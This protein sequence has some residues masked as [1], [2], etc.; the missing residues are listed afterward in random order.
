MFSI[1]SLWFWSSLFHCPSCIPCDYQNCFQFCSPARRSR[2]TVLCWH[3]CTISSVEAH[4]PWRRN[5]HSSR[6]STSV[7][8]PNIP[9]W[10]GRNP[11]KLISVSNE[12]MFVL[13]IHSQLMS[14][15]P[16]PSS[17]VPK[18]VFQKGESIDAGYCIFSKKPR[19]TAIKLD[20]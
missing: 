10:T 4:K 3:H 13:A 6:W 2:Y 11:T 15:L 5:S 9:G 18:E 7:L 19:F 14:W 8:Q 17:I 1:I 12:D 20:D 16:Q